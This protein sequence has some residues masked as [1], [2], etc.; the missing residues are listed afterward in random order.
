MA[1]EDKTE[2]STRPSRSNTFTQEVEAKFPERKNARR[3]INF[4]FRSEGQTEFFRVNFFQE[5]GEFVDSYWI[6]VRDGEV[7]ITPETNSHLKLDKK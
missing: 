1:K 2:V 4:L 3:T 6:E 7:E 5:S